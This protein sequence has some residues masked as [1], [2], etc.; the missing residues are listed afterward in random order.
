MNDV[1]FAAILGVKDEIELLDSCI[2]HL[3]TI[4]VDRIIALDAGSTD[5][6]L[7]C[8]QRNRSERLQLIQFDGLDPAIDAWERVNMEAVRGSGAEWVLFQDADEFWLPAH[9]SLARCAGLDDL[10]VLRV[11]RF[12]VPLGTDGPCTRLPPDLETPLIVAEIP[13]FRQHIEQ[14]P[15]TPWIRGVPVPKVMARREC[16]A[17]LGNACHDIVSTGE[18]PLRKARPRDVVI[19]HLP[20][21]TP[22]RFRRKVDNIRQVFTVYADYFRE[23]PGEA[24]H[25]RRWLSLEDAAAMDREFWRQAFDA[26]TLEAYRRDGIINDAS[27][28]FAKVGVASFEAEPASG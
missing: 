18:A 2:A 3:W 15:D 26:A 8:L 14:H 19:A 11:D 20:F 17:G 22:T 23:H 25:W 1:R 6:S 27:T 24:W 16:I 5:G 13:R 7:E 4:G 28:L 21:S 9:G 10:D 12:N